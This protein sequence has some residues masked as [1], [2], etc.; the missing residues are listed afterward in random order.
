MKKMFAALFRILLLIV[1]VGAAV[2]VYRG[3]DLYRDTIAEASV[4]ERVAELE[5]RPDYLDIADVNPDYL[6]LLLQSEDRRFYEHSGMDWVAV[7]RALCVDLVNQSFEQ[8]GSTITQQL[9]KN[10]CFSFS[11]RLERKVAEV[12]VVYDLESL[13]DKDEILEYYLN[14]AYYGNGCYGLNAASHYY[15]GIDPENLDRMQSLALVYTLKSP[16]NYNPEVYDV[17]QNENFMAD[18]YYQVFPE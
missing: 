16:E 11:K 12:F 4:E 9:A 7:A 5:A 17:S 10:L 2:I 3:Y 15:Y 13:Y 8:G 14:I 6:K 1:V 18:V